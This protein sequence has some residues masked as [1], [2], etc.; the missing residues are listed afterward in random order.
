MR[1]T[2]ILFDLDGT[3]L[4]S[5]ED[6][7]AAANAALADR[8]LPTHDREAF[9]GFIGN[10]VANLFR[11]AIGDAHIN[12]EVEMRACL[13]KFQETYQLQWKVNSRPYDGIAELLNE[14]VQRKCQLAVLSNKPHHFTVKCVDHFFANW[15]FTTVFGQR[16]S[17]PK[18]PAPQAVYEIIELL[19]SSKEQ[20][21]YVGD[22]VVDIQTAQGAGIASAGA[23]WGFRGEEEL[24][25]AGADYVLQSPWDLLDAIR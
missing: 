3:L 2:T 24:N 22:S 11:R 10:G 20:C 16:E 6:I 21:I 1:R 7:A 12:R 13:E 18:K 5:L 15:P 4:D 9:R 19:G 14:L 8:G 23:A 17:V 25:A